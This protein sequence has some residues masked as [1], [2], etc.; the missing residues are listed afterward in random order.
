MRS[1]LET[2][3]V[4]D[5]ALSSKSSHRLWCRSVMAVQE[6]CDEKGGGYPKFSFF[7]TESRRH[8]EN[9]EAVKT[10]GGRFCWAVGFLCIS[11][12]PW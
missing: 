5:G 12:A 8:G 4:V 10:R 6:K 3:A 7:T 1:P 11:V 2:D 9:L